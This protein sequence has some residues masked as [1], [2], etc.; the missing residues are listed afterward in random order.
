MSLTVSLALLLLVSQEVYGPADFVQITGASL[1]AA[2]DNAIAQG[3][4]ANT[5]TF[6]IAYRMPAR[7]NVRV[8]SSDG[9]DVVQTSNAGSIA[10]FFLVRRSDGAIESC[11]SSI[12]ART[13]VSM[14]GRCT[15]LASRPAM[16]ARL[17]W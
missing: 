15:G 4:R 10:L 1:K 12:S 11:E 17:C 14:T 8:N 16:K 9:I 13:S 2:Y 6:W 7:A 5:D 3:K